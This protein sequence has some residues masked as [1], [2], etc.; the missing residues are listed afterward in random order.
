[1]NLLVVGS[2]GREHAL[3]YKLKQSPLCEEIYCAPGNGGIAQI[4]T[5]VDIAADN[6]DALC[7]FAKSHQIGLTVVG[8]EVAL[9]AGIVDLFESEGLKIFGPNKQCAAFEGSKLL[10]KQFLMKHH[11]PTA[12]YKESTNAQ[13]A[14]ESLEQ[15]TYPLVVKAD[16]LAAGKGVIICQNREDAIEAID[17]IMVEK[18]LGD[19][20]DTVVIEEYLDGV[21]TSMLCFL[22][23]NILIPMESSKDYKRI[24]D[25]DEGPNTGGMGTYSPNPFVDE[26]LTEKIG[27]KILEP[28][29]NAFKQEDL[30]Y[31]GVLYV[32]L[33]IVQGEPKVLEFNVRFGDPETQV[34]MLRLKS[35]L[36]KIMLNVTD[37][38]LEDHD[39]EWE[40]NAAVCVVLASAGYPGTYQKGKLIKGFDKVDGNSVVFHAGTKQTE[41][42]IVTAGGRV[43]NICATAEDIE[44]ARQNAYAAVGKINFDGIYYRSDIARIYEKTK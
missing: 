32:G 2:G 17:S 31:K 24:F 7:E 3:I 38:L 19:A 5:C 39:V 29:L 30:N 37:G 12:Y 10:T 22:D 16:G 9:V 6:L 27:K 1:M 41:E 28:I 18:M 8:P 26:K 35:D 40:D 13:D 43:L 23:G 42:G 14:I 11:I 33:M 36:V 21:E 44:Q 34:L 20:G 4:A 15:F 25:N